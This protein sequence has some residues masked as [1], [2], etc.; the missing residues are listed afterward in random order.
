MID[1]KA[2]L[3]ILANM[4][5]RGP[6]ESKGLL[7]KTFPSAALATF[8]VFDQVRLQSF[9]NLAF[10]YNVPSFQALVVG[11]CCMLSH[12]IDFVKGL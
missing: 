10:V 3:K 7:L 4:W 8:P 1:T 9:F 5:N 12:F 11:Y 2:D 6:N